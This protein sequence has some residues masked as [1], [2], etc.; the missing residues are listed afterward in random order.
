MTCT[1]PHR[2]MGIMGYLLIM[3][4]M[5]GQALDLWLAIMIKSSTRAMAFD[6]CQ[7]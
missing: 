7:P 5:A 4:Y 2:K 6:T 3:S 1:A